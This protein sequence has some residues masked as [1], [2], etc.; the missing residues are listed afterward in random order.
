MGSMTDAIIKKITLY[1]FRIHESYKLV[2][3]KKTTSILGE[4]GCGK[5]SVLEAIYIA[6]RGKSFRAVDKD[7]LKRTTDFYRIELEYLNGEKTIVVYDNKD[8]KKKFLI[9]DRK[10]LRLPKKFRYPVVL[11]LPEDLHL[12]SSSPTSK[13]DYF[14]RILSQVDDNYSNSLSRYNK[15]LKQRNELLKQ[16]NISRELLFSW[17]IM[18]A[19]YGVSLRKKRAQLIEMINKRLTDVYLSIADTDDK[20][21]VVYK[22]NSSE[23]LE[24]EY[25]K[26]LNMDYE[27]DVAT[28]HTNFGVHKDDYEF[29]FN[30]S[31]ADGSASRGE[32]RSIIIA[33]K[34]IEAELL[35]EKNNKKPV[36]LLDDVF[37]ELDKTR[38]KCLMENFKDNQVILTSV[39]GA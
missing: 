14:D 1:N 18:L 6:M 10:Y 7:I 22:S 38:Q 37:S 36:V 34:F 12:I 26:L 31:N 25:V 23:I 24:S 17:D 20:V 39:E 16:D 8:L 11:F 21:E 4:N 27:R 35:Y 2:I 30:G 9:Q 32:T 33:L 15:A 19:N 5:T 28:G 3:N 13:R 29:I